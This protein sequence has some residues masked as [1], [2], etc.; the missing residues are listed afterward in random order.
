MINNI[1][2]YLLQLR[3]EMSGCDRAIIQDAL[4]DAE[5]Y[6]R[7]ALENIHVKN[8]G[9]PENEALQPILEEYG[10]PGEIAAAYKRIEPRI[11]VEPRVY[12]TEPPPTPRQNRSLVSGFFGIVIDSRAW[13]S[14]F[15]LLLTLVTGIIYFTWA[16]TGLSLSLGLLILIIGIPFA[17]LY[18]LSIRGLALLEGRLVEAMIG[19]RMPHRPV[20][21][22]RKLGF[23]GRFKA[24]M[25]DKYTWFSLTYMIIH[26]PLGV[27]YFSL[28]V[29]LLFT[30]LWLV[31]RPVLEL[32]FDL[33]A[34]T[35]NVPYYTP[36]WLMPLVVIGGIILFFGTM[37]LVKLLG[38][39]QGKLAKAMLVRQ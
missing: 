5:E 23:W 12:E 37:H 14:L 10:T 15:Y 38:H 9:I 25:T 18:I 4:S 1:D 26:L 24:V 13:S 7:N 20:F 39:L 16:V 31:T 34:F 11:Y 30:A 36:G 2:E 17:G 19:I 27:F 8:P 32:I 6:L 29:S 28:S 3:K 22:N 21:S 33:P 35:I